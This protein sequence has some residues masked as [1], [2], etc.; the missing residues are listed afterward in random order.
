MPVLLILT[1]RPADQWNKRH[2]HQ[3]PYLEVTRSFAAFGHQHEHLSL[4]RIAHWNHHPPAGLQLFDQSGR[5]VVSRGRHDN[6]VKRRSLGPAEVAVTH[7]HL[8]I[9]VA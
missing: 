4:E 5:N 8:D 6:A 1:S 7:A 2:R 3:A 9:F